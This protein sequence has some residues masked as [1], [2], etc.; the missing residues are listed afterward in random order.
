MPKFKHYPY[1]FLIFIGIFTCIFYYYF[2]EFSQ[3]I[4]HPQILNSDA[5]GYLEAGLFYW[6]KHSVH[7]FRTWGYPLFTGLPFALGFNEVQSREF[8]IILNVI[9]YLITACIIFKLLDS[10]Q[11]KWKFII[12][13]VYLLSPGIVAANFTTMSE[14]LF[15]LSICTFVLLTY[16]FLIK[17]TTQYFSASIFF[18]CFSMAVRP[19]NYVLVVCVLIFL[20]ATVTFNFI[21]K[22]NVFSFRLKHILIAFFIFFLTYLLP[23]LAMKKKYGAAEFTFNSNYVLYHYIGSFASSIPH[24]S[25]KIMYDSFH[26]KA[27]SIDVHTT[28]ENKK[29]RQMNEFYKHEWRSILAE[30]KKQLLVAWYL[31][32][33]GNARSG[34]VQ[35][36]L[37]QSIVKKKQLTKALFVISKLQNLSFH[38][39]FI[40][41]VLAFPLVYLK[42]KKEYNASV[43]FLLLLILQ[44]AILIALSALSFW[45]GDRFGIVVYPLV[46]IALAIT[47]NTIETKKIP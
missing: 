32:L 33:K 8:L 41:L 26:S 5:P 28:T 19:I 14:P 42:Y 18:L 20:C 23:I 46:L 35:L 11:S 10:L 3:L 4:H 7:P 27:K 47:M 25:Q 45:Q 29:W 2:V 36:E 39:L 37:A 6:Q 30:K 12:A 16:Y 1:L 13:V 40:L 15:T 17:K 21:F 24:S 22:K 38:I 31:S 43:I 9:F 44:A 34:N